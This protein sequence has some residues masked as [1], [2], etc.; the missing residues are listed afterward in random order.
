MIRLKTCSRS[1]GTLY[2]SWYSESVRCLTQV[3]SWTGMLFLVAAAQGL[4]KLPHHKISLS[5]QSAPIVI[6]SDIGLDGKLDIAF[7]FFSRLGLGVKSVPECISPGLTRPEDSPSVR[8]D[9]MRSSYSVLKFFFAL[10]LDCPS[11]ELMLDVILFSFCLA[12]EDCSFLRPLF[13]VTDLEVLLNPSSSAV[14]ASG[15]SEVF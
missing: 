1:L 7:L 2:M 8:S 6:S 5:I 15:R 9:A 11:L 13:S 10:E 12:S 14:S 3:F 4:V